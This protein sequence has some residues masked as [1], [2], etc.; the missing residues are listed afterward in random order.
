MQIPGIETNEGGDVRWTRFKQIGRLEAKFDNTMT[1]YYM[2]FSAMCK[3][4]CKKSMSKM[5]G[6]SID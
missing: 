4:V 1:D 3:R 5:E 2:A 6:E